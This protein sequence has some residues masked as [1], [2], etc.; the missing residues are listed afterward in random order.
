MQARKSSKRKDSANP[1]TPCTPW[2]L[3]LFCFCDESSH[4]RATEKH[5]LTTTGDESKKN[6]ASSQDYFVEGLSNNSRAIMIAEPFQQFRLG[7]CQWSIEPADHLDE[8]FLLDVVTCC[9]YRPT[10]LETHEH[11]KLSGLRN[12]LMGLSWFRS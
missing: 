1:S 5:N 7:G 3:S 12:R 6:S 9:N 10:L 8:N 4:P 2:M 11:Y